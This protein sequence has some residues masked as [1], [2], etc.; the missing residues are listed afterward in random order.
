MTM[1]VSKTKSLFYTTTLVLLFASHSSPASTNLMNASDPFIGE[2]DY[3]DGINTYKLLISPSTVAGQ[4]YHIY[5]TTPESNGS[6]DY[7][8]KT[9][10]TAFN[11]MYEQVSVTRD[12]A[13]YSVK[14][15][16]P[17]AKTYQYFAPN[18][19]PQ[20]DEVT[21]VWRW[22]NPWGTYKIIISKNSAGSGY[23][24]ASSFS[25]QNGSCG[26]GDPITYDVT[27]NADGSEIFS[28]HDGWYSFKYD[29][30]THVISNPNP[31]STFKV[32]MCIQLA[33]NDA[34]QFTK[35]KSAY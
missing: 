21:G 30:K 35:E 31:G 3:F 7:C 18:H 6:T 29:P 27:K 24:V 15:T 33:G 5:F 20:V 32:G 10:D 13:T 11:C 4:N 34:P 14:L 12:D 2:W 25:S 9:S 1:T 23:Q 8:Q 28:W 22:D 26:S 19:Q 16:D 17:E